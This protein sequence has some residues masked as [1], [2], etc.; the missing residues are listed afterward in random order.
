MEQRCHLA[1]VWLTWL[2]LPLLAIVGALRIGVVAGVVALAVGILG[3]ELYMRWFPRISNG[4][5]L[6]GNATS[7]QIVEFLR[8]AAG[9]PVAGSAAG[10]P[11]QG[12]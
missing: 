7:A 9:L 3:Q 5:L 2:G 6:V 12:R 11:G 1:A 4:R 8:T 10:T